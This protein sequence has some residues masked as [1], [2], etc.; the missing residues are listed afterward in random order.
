MVV[1]LILAAAVSTA[2]DKPVANALEGY[3]YV[4]KRPHCASA[5]LRYL[6][7]LRVVNG[8]CDSPWHVV[9]RQTGRAGALDYDA[10]S[11]RLHR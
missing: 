8:V 9:D 6:S 11:L 4:S 10:A 1:G 2:A 3:S 7:G 5:H